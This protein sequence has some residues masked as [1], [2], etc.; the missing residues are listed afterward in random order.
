MFYP[1]RLLASCVYNYDPDVIKS[2]RKYQRSYHKLMSSIA[3]CQFLKQCLDN[4]LIPKFLRFKVPNNGVFNDAAVDSFQLKLLRSELIKARKA[5]SQNELDLHNSRILL[6]D[7]FPDAMLVSLSVFTRKDGREHYQ[8]LKRNHDKKLQELSQLQ[9]KPLRSSEKTVICEE[10]IELPSVVFN[11]LSFGPKHPVMTKFDS[12]G[13]LADIEGLVRNLN[14]DRLL[15][16]AQCNSQVLDQS[17]SS[18]SSNDSPEC[19]S[20]QERLTRNPSAFG[21]ARETRNPSA[22]GTAR[23]TRNPSFVDRRSS[24]TQGDPGEKTQ[25]EKAVQF[26]KIKNDINALAIQ[27]GRR[28]EKQRP[29]KD[30][31]V[32]KNYLKSNEL[33]AVPFDKGCGFYIMKKSSYNRKLDNVLSADQFVAEPSSKRK[34]C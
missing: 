3:R 32:A 19:C 23:E 11:L 20:S 28:C 22:F 10:G 21:T 7:S 25:A 27:Y 6:V 16:G 26:R 9:E 17:I 2:F 14:P 29:N 18:D 15:N 24:L 13:F 34:K 1:R 30:L 5:K 33:V 4:R 31:E 8:K 12:N